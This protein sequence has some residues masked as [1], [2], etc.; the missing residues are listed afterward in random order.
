[1]TA[2]CIFAMVL[3]MIFGRANHNEHCRFIPVYSMALSFMNAAWP[4]LFRSFGRPPRT[5]KNPETSEDHS[6]N[7]PAIPQTCAPM[8]EVARA[9]GMAELPRRGQPMDP[10]PELLKAQRRQMDALPPPP[11]QSPHLDESIFRAEGSHSYPAARVSDLLLHMGPSSISSLSSG[12]TG[13]IS[14]GSRASLP[15]EM[16]DNVRLLFQPEI[17]GRGPRA[18]PPR[19]TSRRAEIEALGQTYDFSREA[20]PKQAPLQPRARKARP[21]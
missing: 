8:A 20:G 4:S 13:S 12:H 21:S 17:D 7:L 1:M 5:L 3:I 9:Q 10:S 19:T 2:L 18:F 14:L 11:S 15:S 16:S 6:T